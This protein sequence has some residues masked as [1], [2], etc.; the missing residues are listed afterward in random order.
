MVSFVGKPAATH[1][2]VLRVDFAAEDDHG[3]AELALLMAP[4]ARQGELERLPLVKP[5]SQP[6]RARRA[7]AYQDLTAHP[8]A[9]LPV[10]LQLEAVD[11][12]GQKGQSGPLEIVLPAREFRHPLARAVIEERRRLVAAPG[13]GRRRWRAG[14][15]RWPRPGSRRSCRSRSRSACAV[16]AARLAM[17]EARRREPALGRR[18]LVGAGAVHRGRCPVGGRAQAARAAGAAAAGHGRGCAR[19]RSSSS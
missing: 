1:R 4:A 11:A 6:P 3:L 8:Y 14:W 2:Q 12:I 18:S 10:R 15:R 5:A 7:A 19:T 13:G 16:A 17:N 9:G